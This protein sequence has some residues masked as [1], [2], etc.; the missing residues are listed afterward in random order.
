MPVRII[1]CKDPSHANPVV[2]SVSADV[3]G[4]AISHG[5]HTD[6]GVLNKPELDYETLKAEHGSQLHTYLETTYGS[7]MI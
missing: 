4:G 6:I 3:S 2:I 7:E 5:T 1:Y